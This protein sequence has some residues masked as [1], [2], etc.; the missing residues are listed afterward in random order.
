[1]E[2]LSQQPEGSFIVRNSSS[3]P[4]SFA[5]SVKGPQDKITHYLIDK[6]GSEFKLQVHVCH[7]M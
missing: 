2:I 1:M 3:N 7:C 5:L 6:H 4:G